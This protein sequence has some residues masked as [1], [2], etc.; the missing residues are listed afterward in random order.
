VDILELFHLADQM[1]ASDLLVSAGRPPAF[2]CSGRFA[3]SDLPPVEGEAIHAFRRKHLGP[4]NE[5]LYQEHGGFDSSFA[6]EK[7]RFRINFFSTISGGVFE[8]E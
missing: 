6:L 3:A 1:G 5:L 7:T 8:L 2:R 4:D